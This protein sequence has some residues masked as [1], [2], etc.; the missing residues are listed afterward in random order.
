MTE[1]VNSNILLR[2]PRDIEFLFIIFFA[3]VL[4][5]VKSNFSIIN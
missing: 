3:T 4:T 5:V 1:I 2:W